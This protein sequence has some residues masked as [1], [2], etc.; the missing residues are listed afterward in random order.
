MPLYFLSV[1]VLHTGVPG[2][3]E[4]VKRLSILPASSRGDSDFLPA[5]CR[6]SNCLTWTLPCRKCGKVLKGGVGLFCCNSLIPRGSFPPCRNA[7]CGDCY[8]E[9]TE[10]PFPR[11]QGVELDSGDPEDEE[12]DLL[13]DK[14]DLMRYRNGR[15]GDHIMGIPFECDL[16]HFRNVTRRNPVVTDARD[17]MTLITIRRASLD[18]MWARE[19]QTVQSNLSRAVRDHRDATSVCSL[20]FGELPYLPHHEIKDRVGMTMAA[21]VLHASRRAGNYTRNVQFETVRKTPTWINS[22]HDAGETYTGAPVA[23]A[24]PM[25]EPFESHSPARGKWFSRFMRGVKLRMGEVKYQNEPLTSEMVL[26]LDQLLTAEW[27]GTTDERERER[28]EE[29]MCFVLIGFGTSLRGEEVPLVSIRGMKYFWLETEGASDPYIMVALY[30]R[31]KGETGFRWHCLPISDSSRSNIP[32]RRWIAQLMHRRTVVQGRVEGWLF[33]KKDGETKA[34]IRD[35]DGDFST[36]MGL[37]KE[38]RPELFSVGTLMEHFS[39]RRSM[40]RGAVLMTTGKV[41]STVVNMINRWRTK[42]G[43]KGSAPGL[44]MEQTYTNMRDVMHL[45]IEY[46]K[47]L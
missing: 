44:S 31:F 42:E 3:F 23:N 26:A 39:L 33:V 47:A 9:S 10:D 2:C 1:T 34:Q 20:D 43:A 25:V 45:M 8:E 18:A 46:S 12:S 41:S 14:K 36:Y 28:L 5:S 32:F 7:W 4:V 13:L 21:Y 22:M 38:T 6:V 17:A 37:L 16:C 40:R 27:L 30:G 29:L 19:P 11:L 15:N 24:S 35:Y